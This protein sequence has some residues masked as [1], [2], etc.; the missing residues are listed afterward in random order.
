[1]PNAAALESFNKPVVSM[2]KLQKSENA[3]RTISEVANSLDLPTH[4]LRF[5][6]T[7]FS[8][9]SPMKRSGGRRYYKPEDIDVIA[10]IQDLLHNKGY[11]IKGVQQLLLEEKRS[12][13]IAAN[14][15]NLYTILTDA[16]QILQQTK[17]ALQE[18]RHKIVKNS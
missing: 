17:S 4:V 6:E 7:K 2:S 9:I 5:W 15:N 12:Q 1:M 14:S 11:T 13:N 3:Y 10:R 18:S 8:Q 16:Q